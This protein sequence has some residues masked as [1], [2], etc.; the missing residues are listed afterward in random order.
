MFKTNINYFFNPLTPSITLSPQ[1]PTLPSHLHPLTPSPSSH[2]I[3]TTH[4]IPISLPNLQPL[5]NSHPIPNISN[6]I[7]PLT[8]SSSSCHPIL[9][10]SSHPQPHNIT[11]IQLRVGKVLIHVHVLLNKT[12]LP[13]HTCTKLSISL[14]WQYN[15]GFFT[16]VEDW[17]LLFN[18]H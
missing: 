7:H 2:P 3:P 17:L 13:L 12:F 8:P 5:T 16:D 6:H 4:P 15:V 14:S 1:T 10:L 9:I 18:H 11:S